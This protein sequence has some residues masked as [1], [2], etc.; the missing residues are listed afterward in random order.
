MFRKHP[1]R[2]SL[3]YA[4]RYEMQIDRR[5]HSAQRA[6]VASLLLPPAGRRNVEDDYRGKVFRKFQITKADQELVYS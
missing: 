6:T 3:C 5:R 1:T 2:H 4:A